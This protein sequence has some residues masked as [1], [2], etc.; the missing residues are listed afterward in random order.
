MSVET[1]SLQ[2]RE[3]IRETYD[4]DEDTREELA[5]LPAYSPDLKWSDPFGQLVRLAGWN[6]V[7]FASAITES[8]AGMG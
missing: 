4:Q 3:W 6:Y 7:F 1:L 2:L 5:Y 8:K